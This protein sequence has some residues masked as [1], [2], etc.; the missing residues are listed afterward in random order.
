MRRGQA[1]KPESR[2]AMSIA[3]RGRPLTEEHKAKLKAVGKSPARVIGECFYCGDPATTRDHVIAKVRGGTNDPSN[4]VIACFACNTSKK[5]KSV[6]EW[7]EFLR[8]V[9]AR[10]AWA[11]R[12]LARMER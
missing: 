3:H 9:E 2:S 6:D 10:G 11:R 1:H 12:V 7:L 4:L 5:A 8:G